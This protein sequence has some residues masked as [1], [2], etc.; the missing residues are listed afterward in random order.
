M[1]EGQLILSKAQVPQDVD[2]LEV[3]TKPTKGPLR[4]RGVERSGSMLG[5]PQDCWLMDNLW[6]SLQETWGWGWVGETTRKQTVRG[7]AR[8][9]GREMEER[10][11]RGQAGRAPV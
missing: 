9:G 7:Q 11:V 4:E 3:W 10:G 5:V 6:S 2:R 1:L 8:G